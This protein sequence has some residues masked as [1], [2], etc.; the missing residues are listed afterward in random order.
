MH[1]LSTRGRGG[2]AKAAL[3]AT[4]SDIVSGEE[5]EDS[6]DEKDDTTSRGDSQTCQKVE[7][8][9]SEEAAISEKDDDE[10]K[11]AIHNDRT[12]NGQDINDNDKDEEESDEEAALARRF[13]VLSPRV[14]QLCIEIGIAKP[15]SVGRLPEGASHSVFGLEFVGVENRRCILRVPL[16]SYGSQTSHRVLDQVCLLQYLERFSFLKVPRNLGY[17]S[18][19]TN[20]IGCQ[21]ALQS[22]VSGQTMEQVYYKL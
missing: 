15:C 10:L 2:A 20:V 7:I 1:Q 19:T 14:V 17:D 18:T 8:E 11:G 9:K 13:E 3:G 4:D 12:G 21:W 22:R 6:G 5:S 16:R